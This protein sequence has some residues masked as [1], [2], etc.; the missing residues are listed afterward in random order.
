MDTKTP[1]FRIQWPEGAQ[2][3]ME[4]EHLLQIRKNLEVQFKFYLYGQP[5]FKNFHNE[6]KF[7]FFQHFRTSENIDF[8]ILNVFWD[9]SITDDNIDYIDSSG[10]ILEKPPGGWRSRWFTKS[11]FDSMHPNFEPHDEDFERDFFDSSNITL[12][13][14]QEQD[15][16]EKFKMEGLDEEPKY[17]N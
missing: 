16:I 3:K 1:R 17:L 8:G 5:D 10:N 13:R 7:S 12:K 15:E 6:G 4:K 11:E 14:L 9:S 2:L